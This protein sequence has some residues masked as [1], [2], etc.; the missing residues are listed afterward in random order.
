[1]TATESSNLLNACEDIRN[2]IAKIEGDSWLH[3]VYL[4][5]YNKANQLI[6]D[7]YLTEAKE[8]LKLLDEIG[9]RDCSSTRRLRMLLRTKEILK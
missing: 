7:G 2:A 5:A 1:M 9:C 8:A 6:H 3:E 4:P